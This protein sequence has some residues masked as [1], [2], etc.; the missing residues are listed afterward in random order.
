[1]SH[2]ALNAAF[3]ESAERF[4]ARPVVRTL[5]AGSFAHSEYRGR[6]VIEEMLAAA[7]QS[8]RLRMLPECCDDCSASEAEDAL[9]A[10]GAH[11]VLLDLDGPVC[12]VLALVGRLRAAAGENVAFVGLLPPTASVAARLYLPA[13]VDAVV[14]GPFRAASLHRAV[15]DALETECDDALASGAPAFAAR[16]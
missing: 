1:M 16:H 13:V 6:P 15:A 12:A 5:L 7:E 4:R 11:L 9:A 3:D 10:E 14:H 8:W 2:V